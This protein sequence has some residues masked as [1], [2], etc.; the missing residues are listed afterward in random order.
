MKVLQQ[1]YQYW[2]LVDGKPQKCWTKWFDVIFP[3]K[4]KSP[5]QYKGFKG[6]NL[7]NEFRTIEREINK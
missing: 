1:R 6:N 3:K 4:E 5:I 2:G 7:L